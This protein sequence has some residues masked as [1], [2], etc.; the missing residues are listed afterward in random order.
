[1]RI[2]AQVIARP[3]SQTA[4]PCS[5]CSGSPAWPFV[6]H[7]VACLDE[8]AG[9]RG[10]RRAVTFIASAGRYFHQFDSEIKVSDG[11]AQHAWPL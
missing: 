8:I 1:M 9:C 11:H 6:P 10:G 5:H 2:F 3:K 7:L 4:K